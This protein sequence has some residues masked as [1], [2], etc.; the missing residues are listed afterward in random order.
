MGGEMMRL[1]EEE[2]QEVRGVCGGK[3][4][5]GLPIQGLKC[6]TNGIGS[7]MA[8]L[9]Q[10]TLEEGDGRME[11]VFLWE[12]VPRIRFPVV[13]PKELL[14]LLVMVLV[15]LNVHDWRGLEGSTRVL[16]KLACSGS[17]RFA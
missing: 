8:W 3:W 14:G 10:K 9:P 16:Q 17:Q 4:G 5:F 2:C 7:E 12:T 11:G 6:A 1:W 15:W 13:L